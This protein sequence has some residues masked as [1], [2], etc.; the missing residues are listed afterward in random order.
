[1]AD[2]HDSASSSAPNSSHKRSVPAH[3]LA[4]RPPGGK[5]RPAGRPLPRGEHFMTPGATGLRRAVERGSAAPLV[6]LYGLPRWIAPVLLV[7]L[8]LVA[9]AVPD[10]RGGLAALPVLAFVTW[11]AYMSWPSLG[12][13]ARILRVALGVFL[14]LLAAERFGLIF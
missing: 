13:G 2:K 14:V 9:L 4:R 3:P 10:W 12:A 11:L 8:L 5:A 6:Y 1:M 7:V